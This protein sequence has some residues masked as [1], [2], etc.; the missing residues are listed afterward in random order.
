PMQR[1]GIEQRYKGCATLDQQLHTVL[2]ACPRQRGRIAHGGAIGERGRNHFVVLLAHAR[3]S[4]HEVVACKAQ[5]LVARLAHLAPTQGLGHGELAPAERGGARI[6][7]LARR[8]DPFIFWLATLPEPSHPSTSAVSDSAARW[9]VRASS[10]SSPSA[11]T[12]R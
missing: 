3:A 10:S 2:H 9:R 11:S 6:T 12:S 8:G 7:P 5:Q 1:R 4:G